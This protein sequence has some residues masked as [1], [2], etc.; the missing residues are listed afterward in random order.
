VRVDRL[1]GPRTPQ[2]EFMDKKRT[3][4]ALLL[5]FGLA[6]AAWFHPASTRGESPGPDPYTSAQ[7]CAKCHQ[8]IYHYWSESEHARAA[9]KTSFLE[10]LRGAVESGSDQE[11]VQRSCVS[12]HAPTSQASGDYALARPT[13]REGVSCDFCHTVSNVDL[14]KR[15]HPFVLDPG[16]VKRGPLEYASSPFHQTAYSPLHKTSPLL[17]AACHEY[18]N[19]RG[20]RVL[21]TYSEWKAGPYPESGQTCQECHM[22][23]VPGRTVKEGLDST[24]RR[25][26]LHWMSGGGVASRLANGLKLRLDAVDISGSIAQVQVSVVNSGVG[27]AAPGGLSTK[28]LVLSVGIDTGSGDIVHPLERVYHRV[29]RDGQGRELATVAGQFLEAVTIG[30]DT[31]LQPRETRNERFSLPLPSD[32]RAIVARLEYRD[33]SDPQAPPRKTQVAEARRERG[34]P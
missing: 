17:C 19:A 23:V 21:S 7:E 34:R 26:N 4:R 5:M 27:H 32:W 30:E 20:V 6:L 9:T 3:C 24:Q 22:P 12:C 31:R 16:P 29:L 14:S 2:E 28:S 15:D 10:S 33:A 1:A 11:A 25:I 13:T 18:E 8:S